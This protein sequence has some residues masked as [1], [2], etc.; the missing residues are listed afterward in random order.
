MY[1]DKRCSIPCIFKIG[2]SVL[3]YPTA[4]KRNASLG[5]GPGGGPGGISPG[6]RDVGGP[7]GIIGG[8]NLKY[9]GLVYQLTVAELYGNIFVIL[10]QYIFICKIS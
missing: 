9:I 8:G 5:G 3:L 4:L 10:C 6:G 1:H 2:S 7:G